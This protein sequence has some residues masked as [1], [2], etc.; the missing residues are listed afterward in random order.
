MVAG[1]AAGIFCF[2]CRSGFGERLVKLL[3]WGVQD[4]QGGGLGVG[5]GE[6]KGEKEEYSKHSIRFS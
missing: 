1:F 5:G 3:K 4:V 6:I 2:V